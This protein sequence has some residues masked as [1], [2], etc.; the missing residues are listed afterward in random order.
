MRA[1]AHRLLRDF[2]H[3]WRHILRNN[4]NLVTLRVFSRAMIRI[5][6]LDFEAHENTGGHGLRSCM[7]YTVTRLGAI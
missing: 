2:H 5:S 6:T 1:F 7:G 3:Q 4:Y